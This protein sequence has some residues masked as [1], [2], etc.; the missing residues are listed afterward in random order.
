MQA[1]DILASARILLTDPD[2]IRWTDDVLL[3]WLNSG[4]RQICAVRPDAKSVRA[5]VALAP[6]VEQTV[7][8]NGWKFLTAL[9]NINPDGSRGRVLTLV[10]RDELN[11]IDVSWPAAS[12]QAVQRHY[13]T[14]EDSPRVFEVWPPATSASKLRITYAA[15]PTDCSSGASPIDISDVYEGALVDW[16]CYRA[17]GPDSDDQQ[18]AARAASHLTAF[19]T[20]LGVKTQADEASRPKRK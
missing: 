12:G 5:D 1:S 6:G 2:G 16:I 8:A 9:H 7:P 11:A 14:D 20:A 18:D 10:T 17:Y 4:Q 13:T 19:M 3:R 15:L